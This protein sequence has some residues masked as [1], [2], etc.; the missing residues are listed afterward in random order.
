MP[1]IVCARCGKEFKARSTKRK[2]CSF[3][4]SVKASRGVPTHICDYCGKS[5]E[6]RAGETRTKHF[7]CTHQCYAKFR[8]TIT[9]TECRRCGKPFMP[10][11]NGRPFCSVKCYRD[12]Q[13]EH[14]R[15]NIKCAD[16]G[17]MFSCKKTESKSRSR[18]PDCVIKKRNG[19]HSGDV[20]IKCKRC[21]KKFFY[22][23]SDIA[24]GLNRHYCSEICRRPLKTTVCKNCGKEF[25][26]GPASAKIFCSFSCYRKFNGETR[27]ETITRKALDK[28]GLPYFQ[29]HQVSTY[30][31]DFLLY[32]C[33][34]AL[35]IDGVYWHDEAKD[36]KKT[37]FLRKKGF[38]VVRITDTEI[39]G[40]HDVCCLILDRIKPFLNHEVAS[41]GIQQHLQFG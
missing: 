6:R 11:A 19:F 35:E 33:N 29:E 40:A 21:G 23:R 13:R 5:F 20:E 27:P 1:K 32:S 14:G 16:C 36:I 9:V 7:F 39:S 15:I 37:N 25:R 28:L 18:C 24:R 26:T 10:T 2:F 3:P 31:I 4:C 22:K 34:V 12:D 17:E 41:R 38:N 30:S 8:K